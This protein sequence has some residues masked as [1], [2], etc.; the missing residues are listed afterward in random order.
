MPADCPRL[1]I[2]R[3]NL[4][5][6]LADALSFHDIQFESE[7]FNRDFTVTCEVPKFANDLIDGRMMQW[8]Q[9]TG[10]GHA[11]EVI[12]NR[13]L[14]AGPKIDPLAFTEL[15]GVARGFVQHVPN[16]V[17]SLYPG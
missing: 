11:Y 3:E 6:R 12:G 13:V 5:T 1:C 7:E 16:V 2:D 17:P 15:L 8:L 9:G 4:F 10:S 14:V